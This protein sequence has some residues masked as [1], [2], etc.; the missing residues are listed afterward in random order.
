[1]ENH[2]RTDYAEHNKEN[3]PSPSTLSLSVCDCLDFLRRQPDESAGL[4]IADPPYNIG[5]DGG[6]GW[7]EKRPEVEWIDWCLSWTRECARVLKPGRMLV[8]WGT[9]KGS[10]QFMKYKIA[11]DEDATLSTSLIPENEIIWSYNW[12]GRSKRNFARKHEYAWCWHKTGDELLFNA[13][14]VR[15]ERKMRVNPRDKKPFVKGTIPT[16]VWEK[17]NHTTSDDF[18]GW[19]PTTKNIELLRR[20]IRAWTNE[21]DLVI[22]PFSGSGSTAI[23]ALREERR[24]AGS[25]LDRDYATKSLARIRTLTGYEA[26]TPPS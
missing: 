15:V 18:C 3:T 11:V 22:D 20:M 6:R 7:D 17:N 4:I 14:D 19:H 1:M 8:V 24:F 13:D 26:Q 10:N 23:A 16:C 5:F 2:A 21:G 9:L 12:G 25:E